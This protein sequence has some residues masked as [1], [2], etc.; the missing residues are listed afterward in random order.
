MYLPCLSVPGVEA[1]FNYGKEGL[2]FFLNFHYSPL[3]VICG[4]QEIAVTIITESFE[5]EE[6]AYL[7]KGNQRLLFTQKAAELIAQALLANEIVTIQIGSLS[8]DLPFD[9]FIYSFSSLIA[10]I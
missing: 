4:E 6:Q 2:T 10:E 1:E 9:Q 5:Y 7:L 8:I 3:V